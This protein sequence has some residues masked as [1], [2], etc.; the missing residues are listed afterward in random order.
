M[1]FFPVFAKPQPA[2]VFA[3]PNHPSA[4]PI[5]INTCR[6]LSKQTTSTSSRMNTYKKP[7]GR[8]LWLTK[9]LSAPLALLTFALLLSV[10]ISG[11]QQP[12]SSLATR[13]ALHLRH[14]INLSEWF[15]QVYDPK[16]YTKEHFDTW[17]TAQDIALIKAID[18]DHVRLSV[19][20][21]PMFRRRQ[22]DRIPPDYLGYLDAAV[23]MILDQG[24]AV[25]IDIHPD[26]DFK[27]N[28]ATD[29]GFV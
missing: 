26:S 22:A 20:P 3:S 19:N 17:N 21:Q 7:G 11:A 16:G 14:G 6:S 5:R 8:V 29:D 24:L 28:L 4:K 15:A 1:L 25:V 27:H 2:P 12:D 9:Y 10:A 18:F 13:R 23:K